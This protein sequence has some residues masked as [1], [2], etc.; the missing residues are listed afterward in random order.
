MCLRWYRDPTLPVGRTEI[1]RFPHAV[2]EVKLSLSEGET[3]PAWVTELI[4]SGMLTEVHKFS[5]FIH[6]TCTLFPDMVQA[7]PYWVDDESVRPSML[8][9]APAVHPAAAGYVGVGRRGLKQQCVFEEAYSSLLPQDGSLHHIHRADAQVSQANKPRKRGGT[10][11]LE[12]LQHP[13]LGDRPT[14]QL[15]RPRDEAR[16]NGKPGFLDW[17]FLDRCVGGCTMFRDVCN[18]TWLVVHAPHTFVMRASTSM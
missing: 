18:D 10:G 13:L 17:W 3:A 16:R 6:G 11:E 5:K 2:L 14:L 9:S 4:E 1:T 8:M 12:N 7:V 15:I